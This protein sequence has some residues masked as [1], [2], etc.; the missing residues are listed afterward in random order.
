MFTLP[1]LPWAD[2]ALEPV[3]SANTISFHYGKH[4]K[5]YVDNLNNLVK[6]T[7]YENAP[8]EK[9]IN[10]T[11]GKADKAALF[12]N[13]AQIWNHTFYWNSLKGNG[14]GKPGA[15][16][17]QM[18][19]ASFGSFDNFKKELSAT[20]VSQFGS[21][22]GWL[23]L[24][25]GALKIVKTANAEVPFTKGQKPLLTIDVWEHA[26]YLDH[27]NKRAAYV[28]AVIDKLLNWDFAAQNLS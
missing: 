21:G 10:E 12:N 27:Q 14:G 24:D 9:I 15:K 18:I 23:V 3:I 5:T 13:A 6:G 17:A 7:D 4:H 19:D 22:W 25:G 2:N 28:D 16:L 1:P 11:A 20:T 26:Y 8:L